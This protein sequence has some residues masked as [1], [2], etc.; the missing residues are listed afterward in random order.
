MKLDERHFLFADDPELI[1]VKRAM[2]DLSQ[3]DQPSHPATLESISISA[4][5]I[6]P[7]MPAVQLLAD[8]HEGEHAAADG[9]R[10]GRRSL[11]CLLRPQLND[12]EK[13]KA[14]SRN[15]IIFPYLRRLIRD[16][17]VGVRDASPHRD[18]RELRDA[19]RGDQTGVQSEIQ[20]DLHGRI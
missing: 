18:E 12:F 19:G 6:L 2:K 11:A 16:A 1:S 9:G 7:T 17:Q 3:V 14:S 13:I 15:R 8:Q 10:H 20:R 5:D 4:E